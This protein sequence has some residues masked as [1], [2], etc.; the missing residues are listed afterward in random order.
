MKKLKG[1]GRK[2]ADLSRSSTT[3]SIRGKISAP[4]PISTADDEFPIRTP[5][6]GIALPLGQEGLE[7]EPRAAPTPLKL[8]AI[9]QE[10]DMPVLVD[11]PSKATTSAPPSTVPSY[12]NPASQSRQLSPPR[13]SGV[14][15]PSG[16]SEGKPQRKKSTLRTVLGRLFG[17][18][19]KSDGSA[20]EQQGVS[21]RAG[22]HHSVSITYHSMNCELTNLKDPSALR[23]PTGQTPQRSA[24]MPI[25]EFNRALRSH[26]PFAEEPKP[27]GSNDFRDSKDLGWRTRPRRSTTPSRLYDPT[28][29]PGYMNWVGLSPRPASSHARD[30]GAFSGV[31]SDGPI[32]FAVTSGSHPNRRSRSLGQLRDAALQHDVR[33]RSDEIRYWRESYP[34]DPDA[35]SPMSSQ[36]PETG[37]RPATQE[38][39]PSQEQEQHEVPQPFNF[40]SLGELSGMK[41]TQA[42]SLDS[43]VSTLEARLDRMEKAIAN[44]HDRI[45]VSTLPLREYSSRP[46]TDSS[47][48]S[49]PRHAPNKMYQQTHNPQADT[50]YRMENRSYESS[51]PSTTSTQLSKNQSYEELSPRPNY[52]SSPDPAPGMPLSRSNLSARHSESMG[53][54]LS[55]STTIRGIASS[56]PSRTPDRTLS[57]SKNGSLTAHHYSALLNLI[58][59]EQTARQTLEA[60]V[61]SLQQ[62]LQSLTSKSGER[63]SVVYS[64][65]RPMHVPSRQTMGTGEFSSFEHD[66]SG[67]ESEEEIYDSSHEE[68]FKI[69]NK[70][71]GQCADHDD[72]EDELAE[73]EG[74]GGARTLSLSQLTMGKSA[75][76]GVGF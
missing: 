3:S 71:R 6:T 28:R 24:S 73:M 21:P 58:I 20:D 49:L 25:N 19:Q 8:E 26:S 60:Q 59:A 13:G 37:L 63:S 48:Q 22:L 56:S 35:M 52:L 44:L 1:A 39:N 51:R 43:R 7:R 31:D 2:A 27:Q 33:R 67:T 18:K 12:E 5:G 29:T 66:E 9:K 75:L 46:Q 65:P 38:D 41:I 45:S 11:E 47:D 69:Q 50:S 53:R 30:S 4:I 15:N 70:E 72:Y 16:S 32:G 57:L 76:A 64:T 36:R 68:L 23:K 17:R 14:R 74:H 40:G 54:P 62:Q 61:A 34:Y 10:A 55:T 42:A